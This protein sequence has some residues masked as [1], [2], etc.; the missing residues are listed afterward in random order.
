MNSWRTA[1]ES[2]GKGAQK[3]GAEAKK[4]TALKSAVSAL[5]HGEYSD[6]LVVDMATVQYSMITTPWQ[7]S[8]NAIRRRHARLHASLSLAGLKASV[9]SGEIG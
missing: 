5:G 7:A 9:S 6:R 2:E 4:I 3:T 8:R 1:S